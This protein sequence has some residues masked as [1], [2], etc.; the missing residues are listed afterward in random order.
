MISRRAEK[1]EKNISMV[2]PRVDADS[3]EHNDDLGIPRVRGVARI[4]E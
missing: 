4:L 3:V 1:T 2:S